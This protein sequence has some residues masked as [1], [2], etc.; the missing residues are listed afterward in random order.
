[1]IQG[2]MQEEF[3]IDKSETKMLEGLVNTL[4]CFEENLSFCEKK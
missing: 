1:M 3:V 4:R 2:R